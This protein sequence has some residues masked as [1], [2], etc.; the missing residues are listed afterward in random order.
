MF[1]VLSE[2]TFRCDFLMSRDLIY[3]HV[4]RAWRGGKRPASTVLTSGPHGHGGSLHL[5]RTWTRSVNGHS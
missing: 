5:E 1:E 4:P 2:L 3:H